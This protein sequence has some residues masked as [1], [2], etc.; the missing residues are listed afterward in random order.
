[1]RLGVSSVRSVALGFTLVSGNR[2]GQCE[3]FDYDRYWSSSLATAAAASVLAHWTRDAVPAE[4]FTCALLS[5][6]GQLAL[7][8]IH[9]ETYAGVLKECAGRSMRELAV[10][11]SQAF[12]IDHCEVTVAMMS[13]WRLPDRFLGAVLEHERDPEE[14]ETEDASTL[15]MAALLRTAWMLSE[16]CL[17][18][19]DDA[20]QREKLWAGSTDSVLALGLSE[21]DLPR[22]REEVL[23]EWRDWAELL[24]VPTGGFTTTAQP[25]VDAHGASSSEDAAAIAEAELQERNRNVRVLAVD[26][27]PT[28]LRLLTRHLKTAGYEV[29]TAVNG[30]EAL[31]VA[32]HETPHVIVTDWM[33][34][35]MSGVD[36]CRA[37]RRFEPGRN[38]YILLLTGREDAEQI[39]EGFKAGADDYVSKP[40][41]P[42]VLLARVQAG[43]RMVELQQQAERDRRARAEMARDLGLKK[44]QLQGAVWTDFLTGLPNRRYAM[45]RLEKEWKTAVRVGKPLS[46]VMVDIDHFKRVNDVHG[47]DVGDVVLKETARVLR[48]VTRRGD[49]VCR[50]GG[51]EFLVINVNSGIKGAMN[52]A[53]R[54]RSGVERSQME[55][56]TFKGGVTV[57]LGVAEL[58]TSMDVDELIK[59]ADEA[60]YDAKHGGRNTIRT[61]YPD[62]GQSLTG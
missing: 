38:V 4:S 27:D 12:E 8:S 43:Q 20:D 1:M 9:P 42:Q 36:L 7:A 13:E 18:D 22:I 2:T 50:L 24:T 10:A 19:P 55:S 16:L 21:D 59:A 32:L 54:L 58:Q 51:E 35:G 44:R 49:V 25:P 26:D 53:E 17:T 56:G 28:T 48:A 14:A 47:H 6:I 29:L 46:V 5:R 40:F 62:E 31:E 57:S 11:E 60:V 23:A 30:Q 3:S 34:P 41:N 37:L 52:C 39:V 45:D 61:Y 33:M 15:S